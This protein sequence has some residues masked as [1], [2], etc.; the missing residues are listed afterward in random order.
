MEIIGIIIAA[1]VA[2]AIGI[3][4]GNLI[5]KKIL[6]QSAQSAAEKAENILDKA[7][8][9]ADSII[10]EA[11]IEAKDEKLKIKAEVQEENKEKLQEIKQA[12]S[13][14]NQRELS[15]DKRSDSLDAKED[16][17]ES[18][19]VEL[20]SRESKIIDAE[21]RIN[22]QLEHVSGM[23]ADEAKETLLTNLK[24]EVTSQSAFIIKQAEEQTKLE[25]DK[26]AREIISLAIQ[27]KELYF[28]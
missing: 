20:D 18:F 27:P 22:A 17:L 12:E 3:I 16:S 25:A 15:L 28:H 4:A 7:K 5:S 24:D 8:N 19:Q 10:K 6:N 2:L 21:K 23:T 26:K 1:V 11:K 13:R 9:D 14:N